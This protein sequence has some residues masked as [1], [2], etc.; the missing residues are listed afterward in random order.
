MTKRSSAAA[1]AITITSVKIVARGEGAPTLPARRRSP[2][3]YK[4]ANVTTKSAIGAP[5]MT[6]VIT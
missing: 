2:H 6:S 5:I 1:T 4:T 3:L